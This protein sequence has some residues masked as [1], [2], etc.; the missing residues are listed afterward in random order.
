M[1]TQ[2]ALGVQQIHPLITPA[3]DP[4]QAKKNQKNQMLNSHWLFN[5]RA[6]RNVP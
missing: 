1:A 2:T 5:Q 6:K 3:A 4:K